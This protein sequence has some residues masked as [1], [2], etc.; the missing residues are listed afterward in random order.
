VVECTGSEPC[1]AEASGTLKAT[2]VSRPA[3][4]R[5]IK[6]YALKGSSAAIAA[7]AE[8]TL[9]LKL[10]TKAAKAATKALK[11]KKKVTAEVA[12]EVSD[13]AGNGTTL[14]RKLKLKA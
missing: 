9:K 2:Q 13:A 10:P 4:G 3:H 11:A 7:G 8:A 1:Q 6:S 12:V 14:E 5:A